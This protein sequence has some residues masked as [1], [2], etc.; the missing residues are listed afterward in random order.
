MAELGNFNDSEHVS[1]LIEG[2][3]NKDTRRALRGVYD[4]L[5][6]RTNRLSGELR[7]LSVSLD[8][9]LSGIKEEAKDNTESTNKKIDGLFENPH[10]AFDNDVEPVGGIAFGENELAS[11]E[12]AQLGDFG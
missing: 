2:I 3:G 8:S 1:D 11:L 5:D 9:G 10:L 4:T 12:Y 6:R 7:I